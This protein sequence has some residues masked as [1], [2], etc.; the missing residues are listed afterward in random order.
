ML[1]QK[2]NAIWFKLNGLL[3]YVLMHTLTTYFPLYVVNEYPKSGG[4]WVGQMLSDALDI[5]F[6]RNR[7]PA[8]ARAALGAN[9]P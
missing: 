8:S 4:T 7:L 2:N 1:K 9:G 3:R 5:P 6:P